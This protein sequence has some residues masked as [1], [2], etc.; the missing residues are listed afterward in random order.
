MKKE[1]RDPRLPTK[2]QSAFV[3]KLK[4]NNETIYD[5]LSDGHKTKRRSGGA[6]VDSGLVERCISKGL[7]RPIAFDFVGSPMQWGAP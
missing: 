3:A 7:L 4:A 5:D 6:V 2:A 1:K